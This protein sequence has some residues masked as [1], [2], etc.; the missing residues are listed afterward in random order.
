M[1]IF[2]Y[3]DIS[4]IVFLVL[5]GCQGEMQERKR[6]QEKIKLTKTLHEYSHD[7]TGHRVEIWISADGSSSL[8][9]I[10]DMRDILSKLSTVEVRSRVRSQQY[11][12]HLSKLQGSI[13]PG[14]QGHMPL[15]FVV[16]P[17]FSD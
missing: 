4:C 10:D 13:F 1:Y 14:A 17:Y 2:I 8:D 9:T 6:Q 3:I 12:E 16:G 7:D 11:E 15:D 5:S